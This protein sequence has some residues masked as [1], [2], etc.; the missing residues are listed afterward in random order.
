MPSKSLFNNTSK[1]TA[2]VAHSFTQ[3]RARILVGDLCSLSLHPTRWPYPVAG[4]LARFQQ[5]NLNIEIDVS[6]TLH[7]S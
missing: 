1:L 2:P 3:P 6:N 4:T 7:I 5:A